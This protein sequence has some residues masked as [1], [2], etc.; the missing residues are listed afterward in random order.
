[1]VL[2][3]DFGTDSVRAVVV[4]A[5]DGRIAGQAVRNYPRWAEG[6]YCSPR[7]NQFRQHPLDYVESMEA[8]VREALERAGGA[9][10]VG[11]RGIALDTTGSTPCF[12]DSAGRPLSLLPQFA[13]V[14]DAMFILWKDHS[15]VAEAQ[16]INELARGWGGEDFT[17]FEGGIYS[18]E[19]FWAKVLHIVRTNPK[20]ARAAAT[21]VEHC[22]WMPALLS[23]FTDY[24]GL[25][26][27]RCAAGHKAMWHASWGGYPPADFLGRLDPALATIAA[28]LGP[29]TWTADTKAGEL[30]PEWAARLGLPEGIAVSVGAFDA[31]IGAVGG[32]VAPGT[33][34]KIMGTSTCDIMVGPSPS[35]NAL[36]A[37]KG[38]PSGGGGSAGSYTG[39]E[40]LVRGICGQ[41][42]GSVIPGWI[43]YEAGQSAFGDVFAW[44]R[45]LLSWPFRALPGLRFTR[46]GDEAPAEPEEIE[47]LLLPALEAEAARLDPERTGL[48][49][50]DW[51]NGRRTPDAD[52]SL[53]GAFVGL[54]LGT[55]APT[56]Y[57]AL[58]EAAAFGSR[59]IV[60][61]LRS[62][63][64]AIERVAAVG[65][66][67]KK[68]PLVMQISAD[69]LGM[70]IAVSAGDQSCAL[71]AA[72]FA[73]VTAGLHGDLLA[74]QSAMGAGTDR[75]YKP[76]PARREIYDR[77][78]ERYTRLGAFVQSETEAL[79]KE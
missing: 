47:E 58:V 23:G 76:D 43:G 71:G 32:N 42:D 49:A 37:P 5:V 30:C 63:G 54:S 72:M 48:V 75:I 67:A 22:D 12:A 13:E 68:S 9:A 40:R 56:M 61:R 29:D 39:S 2:G 25:K 46:G 69:V 7:D 74:A 79:R 36:G 26:R 11:V 4:E 31:H 45:R 38:K 77:L 62:E 19:W 44:F 66:V 57:R 18:S 78:Y 55:D 59:A 20:I 27:S 70:E 51:L 6:K 60:E 24:R 10:R 64:V 41:V 14:P 3:I 15:A 33:L 1:F 34:L 16:R 21:V 35:A 52:Q 17:K 50:L 53:T 65:G 8:A 73:A 28:S